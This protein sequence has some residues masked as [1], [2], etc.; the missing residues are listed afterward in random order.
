MDYLSFIIPCQSQSSAVYMSSSF[1]HIYD[2]VL[3][4]NMLTK[5]SVKFRLFIP[6]KNELFHADEK[7]RNF[8]VTEI[9][10][11]YP[12]MCDRMNE[13]RY[14]TESFPST[15]RE[16][17][18]GDIGIKWNNDKWKSVQINRFHCLS[19]PIPA[20]IL[21]SARRFMLGNTSNNE[22]CNI[23]PY[24]MNAITNFIVFRWQIHM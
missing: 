4:A 18:A 10:W 3:P 12:N 11:W 22:G 16:Y 24:T 21:I 5:G 2:F 14:G 19:L 8:L 13:F 6:H 9:I 15:F 20:S 7:D 17:T 1:W 23:V